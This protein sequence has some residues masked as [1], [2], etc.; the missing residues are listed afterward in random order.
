MNN[1][2]LSVHIKG[3]SKTYGTVSV[4]RG[5]SFDV[6]PGEFLTLLGPSGCGKTTLLRIIA[7]F[8]KPDCGSVHIG[9]VDVT[10]MP[11]YLRGLGMVFQDYALWPHMN[12]KQH[13]AFGLQLTNLDKEEMDKR[14]AWAL[15]LVG[16]TG[17]EDRRPAKLSGGQKQR[18]A[19]ARAISL[20]AKILLLDEPLSNLDRKLRDTMRVEIRSL[21]KHLGI[22]AIYVTHD[23]QEAL[24]M[25]DRIL[26]LN[27][28]EIQQISEPKALYNTPNSAFVAD[29]VGSANLLPVDIVELER[30][31]AILEMKGIRIDVPINNAAFFTSR[32]A[33]LAIRPE[34]IV[35]TAIGEGTFSGEVQSAIYEGKG[36]ECGIKILGS[37]IA[38]NVSCPSTATIQ[39]GQRVGLAV[40]SGTLVPLRGVLNK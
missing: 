37:D 16:L 9:P 26:V 5:L 28:G 21:Q 6:G 33:L 39:P 2:L 40:L 8:A 38:L 31:R 27:N 20:Q 17:Y 13:L 7:G 12:V 36:T 18:V 29:F 19:L 14:V 30:G 24:T 3:I 35:L 22:T 34:N 15:E 10:N 25:S 23:Q 32:S 11:P 4:L 1:T